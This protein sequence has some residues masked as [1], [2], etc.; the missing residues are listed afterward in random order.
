MDQQIL[1]ETAKILINKIRSASEIGGIWLT[2]SDVSAAIHRNTGISIEPLATKNNI[3]E[4]SIRCHK[5]GLPLISCI[6]VNKGEMI[7]GQ[8][9]FR[10][11]SDLMG[12]KVNKEESE[13]LWLKESVECFG[14]REWDRLL[15]NVNPDYQKT[16]E[17]NKAAQTSIK[18]T[19]THKA[20]DAAKLYKEGKEILKMHIKLERERNPF[21]IRDAKAAFAR[22]HGRL[23]CEVC[24]FDFRYLY[25]DM[26][27]NIAE[28]HHKKMVAD[29]NTAGENTTV[30]DIAIVCSNCHTM[31]HKCNPPITVEELKAIVKRNIG[32]F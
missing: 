9:F 17:Q 27:K 10:L 21:V 22:K 32:N 31:L 14:C 3:G 29:M 18:E 28:G 12:I 15:A 19:E 24:G 4:L 1:F 30:E 26:G 25:G 11:Y 2:Y 5:M 7:P 20:H 8:G 16:I 6:V 23:Y 13:I